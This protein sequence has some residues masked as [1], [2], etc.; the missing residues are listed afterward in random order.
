[1]D[2]SGV[3]PIPTTSLAL[4]PRWCDVSQEAC[5]LFIQDNAKL[6]KL[7][8]QQIQTTYKHGPRAPT[9]LG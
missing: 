1:M 2:L 5:Q 9:L 3:N 6:I 8:V 4:A 7:E